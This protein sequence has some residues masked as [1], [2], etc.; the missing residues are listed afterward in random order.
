MVVKLVPE[1]NVDDLERSLAFYVDL[2]GFHVR[3]QRPEDR[4]AYLERDGAELMMEET[5]GPGRRWHPAPLEHPY[6]RG[7]N[8]QIET[9]NVTALY[10]RLSQAGCSF[11]LDLEE[12]WYRVD[13]RNEGQR[14]F[15][16]IDPDGYLLRF[17]E[18]ID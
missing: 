3:Y 13:A 17:C 5:F 14:Q 11:I 1:L 4:F 16:V 2:L 18:A 10:A 15:V 6:G 8:F 7:I 12:K 9:T